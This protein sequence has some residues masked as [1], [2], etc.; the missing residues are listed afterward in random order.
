MGENDFF[1]FEFIFVISLNINFPNK[2]IYSG[3]IF[4]T[5]PRPLLGKASLLRI[6]FYSQTR[7]LV[8]RLHQ[9]STSELQISCTHH[10]PM[11]F[12]TNTCRSASAD[13]HSGLFGCPLPTHGHLAY[14]SS[15]AFRHTLFW[16]VG[17][18]FFWR[19]VI[20]IFPV[21]FYL[22]FLKKISDKF[23]YQ[24]GIPPPFPQRFVSITEHELN[25]FSTKHILFLYL[26]EVCLYFYSWSFP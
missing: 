4:V 6:I 9:D 26:L 19:C 15:S 21:V 5:Q 2:N 16:K 14:L 10:L 20:F 12:F 18:L 22:K 1:R 11:Y 7:G 8:L 17:S 25:I 24:K 3:N 23:Q 13:L